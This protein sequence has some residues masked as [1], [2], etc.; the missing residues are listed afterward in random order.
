MDSLVYALIFLLSAQTRSE[1]AVLML[2]ALGQAALRGLT[3][4]RNLDKCMLYRS[5]NVGIL[6]MFLT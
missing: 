4:S 1:G 6:G 5:R 3:D 2:C